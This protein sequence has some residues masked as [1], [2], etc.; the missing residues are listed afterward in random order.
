MAQEL[1]AAPYVPLTGTLPPNASMRQA[2]DW[3]ARQQ[4]RHSQGSGFSFT[5]ADCSTDEAL[6]HCNL[7]L[8]QLRQGRAAA[9]YSVRPSQRGRGIAVSALIALTDFGW[10][11]PGLHRIE[12]FI[13]PWNTASVRTAE[14][15]GYL[16]EGLLR[17]H[18][19]IGGTRRDMLLY[20]SI[21]SS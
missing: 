10:T 13:E 1:S 9:G 4:K 19:E 12:L 7:G 21:R 17:S 14:K 3:V 16:P 2:T 18:Q 8:S 5:V 6:G 15:A 20:A 11:I